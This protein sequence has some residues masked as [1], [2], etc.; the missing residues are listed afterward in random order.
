MPKA[1]ETQVIIELTQHT[2]HVLRAANGTVDAGGEC[3][4]ENKPALEALLDAVAP[5]RK[6]E[7]IIA[8]T[9]VWPG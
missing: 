6:T 1:E 8:T 7:G 2:V 5:S 4:L 3:A 9:L